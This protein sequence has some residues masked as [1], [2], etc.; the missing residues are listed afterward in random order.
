MPNKRK[1]MR[2]G[3]RKNKGGEKAK[4]KSQDCC[5]TLKPHNSKF[6]F[7]RMPELCKL[8]FCIWIRRPRRVWPVN[9]FVVKLQNAFFGK[10]VKWGQDFSSCVI[11][12]FCGNR[13]RVWYHMVHKQPRA[14]VHRY[15]MIRRQRRTWKVS[16]RQVCSVRASSPPGVSCER[17]VRG[18]ALSRGFLTR[19]S[20]F[21]W[22]KQ[23]LPFSIFSPVP[24]GTQQE[25]N[26][27]NMFT[28]IISFTWD[29]EKNSLASLCLV[30]DIRKEL[31]P[32]RKE[33]FWMLYFD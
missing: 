5:V 15:H 23:W 21:A 31:R 4:S 2:Q 7:L 13:K 14:C 16:R 9:G 24:R 25:T 10:W 32:K 17:H 26:F 33:P 19:Q 20:T 27:S 1:K 12:W 18:D 6:C 22:Q 28:A 30:Q 8:I 3:K 11:T 29:L